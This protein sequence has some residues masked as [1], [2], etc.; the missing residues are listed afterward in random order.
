MSLALVALSG[1]STISEIRQKPAYATFQATKAAKQVAECVRDGWQEQSFGGPSMVMIQE[2]NGRLTV[3]SPA[4][5]P[6]LEIVDITENTASLY[7]SG[8]IF[9][10]RKKRRAE[11]LKQCI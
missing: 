9:E 7:F 4:G 10:S 1:C 11:V 5:G 6:P 8:G 2:G 3:I